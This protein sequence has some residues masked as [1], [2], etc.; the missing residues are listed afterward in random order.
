MLVRKELEV[1]Y[2]TLFDRHKY[3]V[4]A[5]S[6]MAGGFL[7]GKYLDK[8]PAGSRYKQLYLDF[9]MTLI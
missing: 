4:A 1:E 9:L 8:I 2:E 7:T 5:W 3:S 6:P